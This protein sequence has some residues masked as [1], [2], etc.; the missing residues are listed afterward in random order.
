MSK[1]E[2]SIVSAKNTPLDK[3]C[4]SSTL[5]S[6]ASAHHS[7]PS[8]A[9]PCPLAGHT[10]ETQETSLCDTSQ[11]ALHPARTTF[12]SRNTVPAP[13]ANRLSRAREFLPLPVLVPRRKPRSAPWT[14][15]SPMPPSLRKALPRCLAAVRRIP[16]AKTHHSSKTEP[17]PS[18][19]ESCCWHTQALAGRWLRGQT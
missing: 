13:L 4:P 10:D 5:R 2:P 14:A 8:P 17:P 9:L 7:T 15:L 11:S 6:P 18:I 12:P 1:Y 19:H 16:R 3:S